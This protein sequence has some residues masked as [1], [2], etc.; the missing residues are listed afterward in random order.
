MT[1]IEIDWDDIKDQISDKEILS[2]AELRSLE[3]G[4]SECDNREEDFTWDTLQKE[5]LIKA[6][7]LLR[8]QGDLTNAHRLDDAL[9]GIR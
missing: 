8:S 6:I 9:A 1:M 2:E 4:C 5:A 3:F 7:D